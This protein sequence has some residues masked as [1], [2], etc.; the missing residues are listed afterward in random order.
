RLTVAVASVRLD[1]DSSSPGW[2][3]VA[4]PQRGEG[5]ALDGAVLGVGGGAGVAD[6][7]PACGRWRGRRR[8]RPRWGARVHHASLAEGPASYG[9]LTGRADL[10]L[11]MLGRF[12]D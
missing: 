6:P 2:L 3:R 12:L 11:P 5:V 7:Q 8:G 10:L 9:T 4:R 1:R